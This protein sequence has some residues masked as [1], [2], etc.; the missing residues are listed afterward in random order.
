M[1]P[2]IHPPGCIPPK[3]SLSPFPI[4]QSSI[5]PSGNTEL[6]FVKTRHFPSVKLINVLKTR[7]QDTGNG[8]QNYQTCITDSGF[9][10][11]AV[12]ACSRANTWVTAR[13][14]FPK[15]T[16]LKNCHHFWWNFANLLVQLKEKRLLW[17]VRN[18]TLCSILIS[19]AIITCSAE[20]SRGFVCLKGNS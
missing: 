14:P 9:P 3:I 8:E 1:N 20:T 11:P 12:A 16:E 10:F 5:N 7:S 18:N 4:S 13:K 2:L 6:K 15:S 19:E 17:P